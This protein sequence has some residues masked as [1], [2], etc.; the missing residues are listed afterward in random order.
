M[1]GLGFMF[2][3]FYTAGLTNNFIVPFSIAGGHLLWQVWS[4][5]IN[6]SSNLHKRFISNGYIFGPL[7]SLSIIA[8]HF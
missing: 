3:S 2:N 8:G 1:I 5:D 4:A 7:I 6:D